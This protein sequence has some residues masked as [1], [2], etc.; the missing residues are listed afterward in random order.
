PFVAACDDMPILKFQDLVCWQRANEL[1]LA[2]YR[3]LDHT[4]AK[5]DFSFCHQL[6]ESAASAP[7][8]LAEGFGIYVHGDSA[9]YARI[10]KA[11]LMETQ[12]RLRDGVDRGHWTEEDIAPILSISRSA[13]GATV[14]WITYLQKSKA[15]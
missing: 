7:S 2:V 4:R 11:S 5:R 6:K 9:R 8:N 12:N 13:V 14:G 3:L 10:A 15:P 1:K